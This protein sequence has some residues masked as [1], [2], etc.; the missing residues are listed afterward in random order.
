[1]ANIQEVINELAAEE[2]AGTSL[3]NNQIAQSK[4][5]YSGPTMEMDCYKCGK[6]F[7]IKSSRFD[8]ERDFDPTEWECPTCE[9]IDDDREKA[10]QDAMDQQMMAEEAVGL[11]VVD[12]DDIDVLDDGY[13]S[14][15]N[16]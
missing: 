7:T 2:A 5:V 10:D 1:M 11:P 6:S 13:H 3:F 16:I 12:V 8:P 14:R 15:H 9:K 4:V